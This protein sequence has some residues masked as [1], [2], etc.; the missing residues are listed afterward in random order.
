MNVSQSQDQ[1]LVR[2]GRASSPSNLTM[3]SDPSSRAAEAYRSL[4]AS[5]KF[6]D[7]QPPIRSVLLADT[8]SGEQH[9]ALAA[10][11]A[12]AIAL[13]GDS[14][15][16]IDANLRTPRLHEYLGTRREPGLADW[17]AAGDSEAVA[18]VLATPIDGL[19]FLP[20]GSAAKLNESGSTSADHLGSALFKSLLD[21]LRSETEFLVFDAPPLSEVGDGLAVAARAD[22]VLL[23]V[24]SGRTKR[25]AAQRAKESLDRIGARVLGAVL[26]D[27]GG[28]FRFRG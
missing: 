14:V 24:R 2:D 17:L 6:A 13:A 4:R 10:N 25:A 12:A 1:T 26:T 18:P 15:I 11:L 23:L 27:A 9:C 19:R 8:G 7:V 5:V 20:A 16:L 28:R 3:L 21:R 22:A